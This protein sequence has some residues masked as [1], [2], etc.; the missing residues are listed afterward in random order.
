MQ[1][2]QQQV[3]IQELS[4][5][6]LK[7]AIIQVT[8]QE[9]ANRKLLD[10]IFDEINRRE[11]KRKFEESLKKAGQAVPMPQTINLPKLKKLTDNDSANAATRMGYTGSFN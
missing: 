4:E 11:E 1:N 9:V 2:Q 8:A 10:I 7:N 6:Q 5:D 3:N